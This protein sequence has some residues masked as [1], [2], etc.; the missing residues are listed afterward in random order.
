MST[1]AFQ[2]NDVAGVADVERRRCEAWSGEDLSPLEELLD[3]ELWYVHTNGRRDSKRSLIDLL[4]VGTR[5]AQRD[6]LEIQVYGDVAVTTGGLVIA[7]PSADGTAS[8]TFVSDVLQVWRRRD[9]EWRLIAQQSTPRA[10]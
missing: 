6:S 5:T 2:G 8:Q 1:A 4:K 9:G 7:V 10:A 3:E